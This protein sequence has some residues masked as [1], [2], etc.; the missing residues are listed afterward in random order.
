MGLFSQDSF[1]YVSRGRLFVLDQYSYFSFFYLEMA[2]SKNHTAHNQSYK[3]HRNGIKKPKQGKYRSTKGVCF[4]SSF[5]LST[6]LTLFLHLF[7][8][9]DGQKIF[10]KPKIR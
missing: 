5:T 2:K 9:L 7:F 4:L 8:L 3:A 10:E 1:P 6:L